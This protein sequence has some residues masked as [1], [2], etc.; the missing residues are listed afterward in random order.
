MP[1]LPLIEVAEAE[2]GVPVVSAVTAAAFTL[3]RRLH[4]P[5]VLPDAGGLLKHNRRKTR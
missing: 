1:S 5:T 3:L 4:L 2:F